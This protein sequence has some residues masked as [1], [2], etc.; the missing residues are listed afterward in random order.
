MFK[1]LDSAVGIII[2]IL[3]LK[4]TMTQEVGDLFNE[5]IIRFL[6]LINN[7]LMQVNV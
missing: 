7:I 1:L 4:W 6:T 3:I 2:L 5:I